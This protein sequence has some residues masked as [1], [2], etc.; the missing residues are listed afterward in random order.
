M[1]I[2][3]G[4]NFIFACFFLNSQTQWHTR[5]DHERLSQ[6]DSL[7]YDMHYQLKRK[8]V[9]L[10]WQNRSFVDTSTDMLRPGHVENILQMTLEKSEPNIGSV[11]QK[12]PK[13]VIFK[14][15]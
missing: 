1:F 11:V 8:T 9:I 4:Y 10:F 12:T 5:Q 2:R 3:V 15:S 6:K 7:L 13:V 14:Q